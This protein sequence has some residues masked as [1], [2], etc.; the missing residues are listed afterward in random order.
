M[1]KPSACGYP[2][3]TNT[4]IQPGVTLKPAGCLVANTPGQVI[5]NVTLV[6]C[7]INVYA[8]GVIIRNVKILKTNPEMWAI[9][10]AGAGSATIS[11]VEVSGRDKSAGALQYA[12][13]NQ[14][15]NRVTIDRVNLH[16]CADCVQGEAI[17]MTNS[18]IHDLAYPAGAHIDGFQCNERCG[19]TLRHNT[20]LN[21]WPQ[22]AAIALFGDFGTPANSVI[23]DNLLAGGGYTIYGGVSASTNIKI[24]NNRF[25]TLY[26]PRSGYYGHLTRLNTSGVGNTWTGNIWDATGRPL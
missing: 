17:T 12:I 22:T 23:D 18:Y 25:S 6:D 21:E 4:G 8:P 26:Y 7:D 20:I 9:R 2:D 5:E 10:V 24:T 3:A 15:L 11:H 16:H 1:V 13:L 19:V 14:T